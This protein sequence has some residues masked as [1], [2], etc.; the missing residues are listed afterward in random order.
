MQKYMYNQFHLPKIFTQ[1]HVSMETHEKVP[2]AVSAKGSRGSMGTLRV[3]LTGLLTVTMH[4]HV[5]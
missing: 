4:S 3:C 1:V 5:T 2:R